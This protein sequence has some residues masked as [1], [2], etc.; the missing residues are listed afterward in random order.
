MSITTVNQLETAL[1]AQYIR[2]VRNRSS[3]TNTTAGESI[4]T[5]RSTGNPAQGAIPAAA[6][7]CNNTTTGGFNWGGT[8]IL[9]ANTDAYLGSLEVSCATAGTTVEIHDRLV[10]S[11]GL[12][13]TVTT[14]QTAA[15]F[16]LSTL[17]ATNN[18]AERIGDS[19]Y[20]DVQWW[21]EFYTDIGGTAVSATVAVTYNDGTTGT[22]TIPSPFGRRSGKLIGLNQYIPA[23]DAG[24]FIRGIVSI[25]HATTGTAGSYGFT[26]T[27]YRASAYAP[28]ANQNYKAG[29]TQIG[30][31]K[32]FDESC[33]TTHVVTPT[34]ATGVVNYYSKLIFG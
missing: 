16:D 20:S 23:V 13:G 8:G 12:S 19:N 24:K 26:A 10:H 11:G 4:S 18:L 5:W 29:W 6:A 15:S 27:R 1:D 28:L 31:P 7:V 3:I 9:G 17:L 30:L 34:T 14:A 33:L 32:I 21:V 25:T 2:M 22:L